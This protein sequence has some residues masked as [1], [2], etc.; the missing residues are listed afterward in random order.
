LQALG[1][2]Y[3]RSCFCTF[4]EKSTYFYVAADEMSY[5]ESH[6]NKVC[7]LHISGLLTA[8]KCTNVCW[9]IFFSLL[10][11]SFM[12]TV[13]WAYTF[14]V[15]IDDI[16]SDSIQMTIMYF[17]ISTI[18]GHIFANCM[19]VFHKTEVQTVILRC[20]T[21]LYLK[22]W[23]YDSCFSSEVSKLSSAN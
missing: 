1:L 19:F 2:E 11:F 4:L 12:G 13:S 17:N 23:K 16:Y 20:L 22:F 21:G 9:R 10:L 7:N 14:W 6:V 3:L 18:S 5:S 8:A 15:R